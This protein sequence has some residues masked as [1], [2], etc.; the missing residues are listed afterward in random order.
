[1]KPKFKLAL[2]WIIFS[3]LFLCSIQILFS[4]PAPSKWLEA[5]WT[6]GDLI[7]FIGT[8]VLGCI[9]VWQTKK[10]NE[11]SLKLMEI[12]NNRHKLETQPFVMIVDYQAY[13]VDW[14]TIQNNPEQIYIAIGDLD[15]KNDLV[16]L[17]LTFQNTTES[18]LTL[19]Y[20]KGTSSALRLGKSMVNQPNFKLY[21][22]PS[23]SDTIILYADRSIMNKL[24]KECTTLEVIL[25]NRVAERYIETVDIII[26]N[27]L[28]TTVNGDNK[29]FC[30]AYIQNYSIN[31]FTDDTAGNRLAKLVKAINKNS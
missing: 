18:F 19:E 23:D 3:V 27:L 15:N 4:I 12:E 25:E 13:N 10:A 21:L 28:N 31:P 20:K 30:S 17:A 24:V 26:T 7:S 16:A 29:L 8:I 5:V 6:A 2:L 1:M 14:Q 11:V 22:Q 9:T